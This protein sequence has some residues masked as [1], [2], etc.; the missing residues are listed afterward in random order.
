MDPRTKRLDALWRD[1]IR[2]RD[3]VCCRYCRKNVGTATHHIFSRRHKATRWDP[4]N[5]I[6]LCFYCHIR[7]AHE[8]PEIFREFLLRWFPPGQFEKLKMRAQGI[9]GRIDHALVEMTL[10]EYIKEVKGAAAKKA[11][12]GAVVGRS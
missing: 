12:A 2:A 7:L 6:L 3:G 10:N 5:G 11:C 9:M 8:D 4:Q 1:A